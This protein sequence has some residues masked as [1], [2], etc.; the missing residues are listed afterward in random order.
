MAAESG[1]YDGP[2]RQCSVMDYAHPDRFPTA[3]LAY[4]PIRIESGSLIKGVTVCTNPGFVT[5][6]SSAR[7]R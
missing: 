3:R 5:L 4:Q 2:K 6:R 1:Q 7:N